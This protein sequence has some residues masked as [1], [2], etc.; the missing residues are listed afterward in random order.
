[1][2]IIAG[3]IDL[4]PGSA[5][6]LL[7]MVFAVMVKM[8]GVNKACVSLDSAPNIATTPSPRLAA[9]GLSFCR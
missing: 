1:M 4:S 5:I 6:A 3:G 2:V 7:T 8:A 9:N